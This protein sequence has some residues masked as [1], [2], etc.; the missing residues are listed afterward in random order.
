[1]KK[2]INGT[3]YEAVAT[4]SKKKDADFVAQQYRDRGW[5]AKVTRVKNASGISYIVWVQETKVHTEYKTPNYRKKRK[6][7]YE[8]SDKGETVKL[9]KSK[10]PKEEKF[11]KEEKEETVVYKSPKPH[12]PS[13]LGRAI[14][15]SA[16]KAWKHLRTPVNTKAEAKK[17]AK[18]FGKILFGKHKKWVGRF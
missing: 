11:E 12:K 1:M 16:G 13:K 14:K 10:E 7:D 18:K 5:F 8:L 17:R 6:K 3:Y 15:K 9:F 4:E 2:L